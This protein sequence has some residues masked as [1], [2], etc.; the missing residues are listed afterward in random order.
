MNQVN[1]GEWTRIG[2]V[3]PAAV[4]DTI[5][6]YCDQISPRGILW[7][8]SCLSIEELTAESFERNLA[9]IDQSA[10]H[11][12]QAGAQFIIL[13]GSPVFRWKGTGFHQELIARAEALTGVPTTTTQRAAL[14]ALQYLGAR[15]L[16]V[17]SPYEREVNERTQNFLEAS[18]FTVLGI[19]GLGKRS[20]VDMSN[21][22]SEASYRIAREVLEESPGAEAI[23]LPC[24]RWPVINNIAR[25]EAE[26]GIPVVTSVQSM[27]WS[28]LK[29][30]GWKGA[31][32]GY[33][34]LLEEGGA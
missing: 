8:H 19:K 25:L 23:Y 26:T 33:G 7:V 15:R 18:G 14:D 24:A 2:H 21:L 6:L 17:A 22:P 1:Y 29:R 9:G 12:A 5:A 34:R 32:T 4:V 16:V 11:L 27:L 13:G 3:N 31:V 28:A 30:L 20:A 10:Q